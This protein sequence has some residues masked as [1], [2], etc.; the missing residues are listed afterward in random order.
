MMMKAGSIIMM[1]M[2][3]LGVLPERIMVI[4]GSEQVVGLQSLME[5][6]GQNICME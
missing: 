1:I 4:S 5:I 6:A 3:P 2:Q